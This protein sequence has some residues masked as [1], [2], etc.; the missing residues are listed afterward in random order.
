VVIVQ[1]DKMDTSE[2]PGNGV[3]LFLPVYN[4]ARIIR[5]NLRKCYSALSQTQHCFEIIIVDD[6][7]SDKTYRF[8][9]AINSGCQ[10]TGAQIRFVS[11]TKGPSR[12]ENLA[13]SFPLAQY[14][15]LGYIDADLSCDISYFLEA[16]RLLKA[17]DADIVIGSRYI[18]GAKIKRR[19]SRLMISLIYNYVLRIVLGSKLK[20]H[21]CG[22]KI[23]RKSRAMPI[24]E[25]MG[26]DEEYVRGWFWDAEFLIRAKRAGLKIIELPVKWAYA[27]SSSFNFLREIK[28][29]AAI[30]KLKK[31]LNQ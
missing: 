12:R 31:S 24:I 14:E 15:I 5:N 22:L 10:Q 27:E 19:L 16:L 20:D 29:V 30:V 17:Q 6:N 9:K 25:K 1:D 18:P 23:F 28:C 2:H 8:G 11:Y 7:S 26:Y 21:Q 13:R 4:S 3:S